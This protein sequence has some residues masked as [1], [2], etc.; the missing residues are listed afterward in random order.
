[1][2][3]TFDGF[4]TKGIWGSGMVDDRTIISMIPPN[5]RMPDGFHECGWEIS[6]AAGMVSIF[7]GKLAE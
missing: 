2:N 3:S 5:T 6:A 7:K 4:T 1:M